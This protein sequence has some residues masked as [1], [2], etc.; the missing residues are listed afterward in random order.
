[1]AAFLIKILCTIGFLFLCYVFVK[2]GNQSNSAQNFK[3]IFNPR[4]FLIDYF[5]SSYAFII[6]FAMFSVLSVSF[7][8]KIIVLTLVVI[9]TTAVIS[10][11]FTNLSGL[12]IKERYEKVQK[13]AFSHVLFSTLFNKF[14]TNL[15][16]MV[17][18][19]T[20]L[21]WLIAIVIFWIYPLYDLNATAW[22]AILIYVPFIVVQLFMS[23]ITSYLSS[24][25]IDD[26][27]RNFQLVRSF[28]T[29]FFSIFTFIIPYIIIRYQLQNNTFPLPSFWWF[30]ILPLAL[31]LI[32]VLIPY[33]IG[34]KKYASQVTDNTEWLVEW[35]QDTLNIL[36]F[37]DKNIQQQEI[38]EKLEK[39]NA[40]IGEKNSDENTQRYLSLINS[41][42]TFFDQ[43]LD[44][45][46]NFF[47]ENGDKL[48]GWDTNISYLDKLKEVHDNFVYP[49]KTSIKEYL[50]YNIEFLK[51]EAPQKNSFVGYAITILAGIATFV[52]KFFE[53][54]INNYVRHL[55][56]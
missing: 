56:S 20:I 44:S 13:L 43:S 33:F 4:N 42:G 29:I 11:L 55:F 30:I 7:H 21:S 17:G 39:L 15:T 49:D 24:E 40:K 48:K 5:H 50:K 10:F 45:I 16:K 1:M 27:L 23:T 34:I 19:I 12:S 37:T 3:K 36:N 46:H 28:A 53:T 47:K 2:T 51:E 8:Y 22:M 35:M 41:P 26:D 38:A 32:S 25:N 18:F 31:L 52:Y 54:D 6:V 9:I 14:Q